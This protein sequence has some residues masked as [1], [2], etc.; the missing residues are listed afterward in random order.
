VLGQPD[1]AMAASL[2]DGLEG[3]GVGIVSTTAANRIV[4]FNRVAQRVLGLDPKRHPDQPLGPLLRDPQLAEF[5]HGAAT[6][7]EILCGR[8]SVHEPVVA[9]L[10]LSVRPLLS[11]NGRV[12]GRLLLFC[13]FTTERRVQ[14]TLS[15]TAARKLIDLTERWNDNGEA[16]NGLTQSEVRVLRC[17]GG[18]L[19]NPQIG[20]RLHI[21]TATVRSHLKHVYRKIGV[22]SRSEAISYAIR[23]GLVED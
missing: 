6:A 23:H 15:E 9:E 7:H 2:F 18:G 14:V 12:S 13:D 5:W 10:K 3:L 1:P 8:V 20:R 19:S 11:A 21:S 22:T 17:V 4:W 16:H